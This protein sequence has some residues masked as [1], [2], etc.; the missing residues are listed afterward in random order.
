LMMTFRVTR[1][2]INNSVKKTGLALSLSPDHGKRGGFDMFL[3]LTNTGDEG[4][5]ET[6]NKV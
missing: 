3:P 2:I 5:S 4:I 1:E 6:S